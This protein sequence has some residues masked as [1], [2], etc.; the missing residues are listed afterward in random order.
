MGSSVPHPDTLR[1]FGDKQY[2]QPDEQDTR[3]VIQM[4]GTADQI[5]VLV[6][7]KDARAVRR[8]VASPGA[9]TRA[10]IPYAAW[11]LMLLEAGLVATPGKA[12]TAK[13]T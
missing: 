11:R 6:G 4:L 9:R 5:A 2:R 1:P 3:A 8:W 7:V 13:K 10:P 12:A